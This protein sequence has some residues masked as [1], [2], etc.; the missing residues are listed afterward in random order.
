MNGDIA[1]DR[2]VRAFR[3]V[4]PREYDRAVV[5]LETRGRAIGDFLHAALRRFLQNPDSALAELDREGV[6]PQ[7]RP[8]GR[9]SVMS[10]YAV[11]VNDQWLGE[12]DLGVERFWDYPMAYRFEPADRY[13]PLYGRELTLRCAELLDEQ[14]ITP[15]AARV[16]TEQCRE[17]A[18]RI[19]YAVQ[20]VL[21]GP[22]V[23]GT[24]A[25]TEWEAARERRRVELD[26][27]PSGQD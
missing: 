6:W 10:A 15:Y 14:R 22:P 13:N 20:D 4:D 12:P 7:P 24:P 27:Q 18:V 23:L 2:G 17:V 16:L 8:A 1:A 5:E 11:R 25:R 3:P 19:T 21:F 26:T 9:R